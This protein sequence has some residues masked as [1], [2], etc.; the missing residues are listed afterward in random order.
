[1][2]TKSHETLIHEYLYED[3]LKDRTHLLELGY[4]AHL[5]PGDEIH[6]IY[7]EL[8]D[9][10][11]LNCA[12]CYRKSWDEDQFNLDMSEDVLKKVEASLK[13]VKG[14]KKLVLGGIGEPLYHPQILE[15]L[16]RFSQY[17]LHI[18]SNGTM[19]S[20]AMVD[21]LVGRVQEITISV[22]GVGK[23]FEAIRGIS[24]D[25][26][27]EGIRRLQQRKSELD[28]A[29][30][31]ISLQFVASRQNID[32]IY[33]VLDLA[34]ELGCGKL[35]LSHLIPQTEENKHQYLY[36]FAGLT[37]HETQLLFHKIRMYSHRKTVTV[38]FP[39]AVLKTERACAFIEDV[40]TYITAGGDVVPCYRF[41]HPYEEYVFGRK[42]QVTKHSFGSL[43][44]KKLLE[45]WNS[46]DYQRFRY[47]IHCNFYPSCMDCDLVEGCEYATETKEDCYGVQPTCADCLWARRFVMCP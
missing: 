42:K 1:M 36:G 9:R 2:E 10:C 11:N 46:V 13:E 43:K 3:N 33:A 23:A 12:I 15:I 19:M 4:R 22:D 29:W 16:E 21:A 34:H 28:T 31:R 7:L 47:Q 35:I 20:A 14:I 40:T 44:E 5:L 41:S 38:Q 39:Q 8:T 45:I 26:V 6:K 25:V 18:T 17:P 32:Q 24:V 37:S 27:A 30:P